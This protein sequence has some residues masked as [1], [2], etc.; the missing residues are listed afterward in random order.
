[1]PGVSGG[2]VVVSSGGG[3]EPVWAPDGKRLF[4]RSGPQFIEASVTTAPAFAVTGRRMLF[5]STFLGA[6]F[7]A[8][9][10]VM[11]D[12][13]SFVMLEQVDEQRELVVTMNWREELRQRTTGK[14]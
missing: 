1:M 4:Y 3:A 5:E 10:D 6:P 13:K 8:N 12:G 11:R 7:H 9:Y 2:R 14:R